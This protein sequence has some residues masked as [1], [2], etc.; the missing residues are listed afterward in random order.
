MWEQLGS[1]L[2]YL[3]CIVAVIG[4]AYWTTRKLG[5]VPGA[6]VLG[7]Q[8]NP[9]RIQLLAQLSLGRDEK[10]LVVQTGGRT[11]L[12]GAASGGI[13]CLAEFTEED[14]QVWRESSA[15]VESPGGFS[16]V[17]RSVSGKKKQE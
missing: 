3:F 5:T 11:F 2:W 1:L 12:L 6:A 14:L 8:K 13:S 15:P 9:L 17:F 4:L 16:E 10:L 7:R